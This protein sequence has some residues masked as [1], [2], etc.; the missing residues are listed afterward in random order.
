MT[1]SKALAARV[2]AAGR[3]YIIGNGGSFA[4]A[5]H[6]CNDL[7]MCGIRAFVIDPATLTASANDHGYETVFERWI[8]TVG[9]RGDL[10]IALSGSG[11]SPNII[12]AMAKARELGMDVHLETRFLRGTDM[13]CSEEEQIRVGH[14]LMRELRQ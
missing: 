1:D 6:I 12:R 3:V 2:R 8:G 14:D 13:Q 9:E 11:T 5:G 10:L 7:L 4:N